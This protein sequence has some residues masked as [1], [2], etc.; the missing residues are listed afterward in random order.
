VKKPKDEG[1]LLHRPSKDSAFTLSELCRRTCP[2][3]DV[4][5]C[6]SQNGKDEIVV[7][8]DD[9]VSVA[10]SELLSRMGRSVFS[11]EA[12]E[13]EVASAREKAGANLRLVTDEDGQVFGRACIS[14]GSA[15]YDFNTRNVDLEGVVTV[16]GLRAA[17]MTGVT[18][19][20]VGH[21]LRASR[22]SAR[23]SAPL[24]VLKKW[25]EEQTEVI[26]RLWDDEG[27]QSACAQ[28]VRMFGGQTRGL[29]IAIFQGRW[30]SA[31]ELSVM[32]NPPETILLVD[33]YVK[34]RLELLES[35]LICDSVFIVGGGG[36]I[37]GLIQGSSN[38]LWP[39]P[40][41]EDPTWQDN[42]F[43]K[44]T[45][46]GAVIESLASAWGTPVEDV[47]ASNDLKRESNA[48]VATEGE[49]QIKMGAIHVRRPK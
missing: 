20:L 6:V 26:P 48:T 9:W 32:P 39:V 10:P 13:D 21:P 8:G 30:W 5:L 2:A 25:A 24:H 31:D 23:P 46:T 44:Y 7:S 34:S 11:D 47:L 37:P 22:D 49:R 36:G 12:T 28:Y 38:H 14:R 15:H 16:G 18:G 33:A 42:W 27:S 41:G 29:P 1:G 40:I 43:M 3:I 35:Y 17:R 19:I 4:D 45:L